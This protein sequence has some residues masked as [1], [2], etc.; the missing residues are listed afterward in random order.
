MEL[1]K[2]IEKLNYIKTI[3]DLKDYVKDNKCMLGEAIDVVL[4]HLTKQEKLIELMTQ[5]IDD[6]DYTAEFC[7]SK[8]ECNEQCRTCIIQFFEKKAEEDSKCM[9]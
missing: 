9:K 5:W 6:R 7:E 3:R 2:V 4:N 8:T 1:E